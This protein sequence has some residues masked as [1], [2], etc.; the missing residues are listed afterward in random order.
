MPGP[1]L[2]ALGR[3]LRS[4]EEG[5]GPSIGDKLG[6]K[7]QDWLLLYDDYDC[8]KPEGLAQK[9]AEIA[10]EAGYR[11]VRAPECEDEYIVMQKGSNCLFIQKT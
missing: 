9:I 11:K 4:Q 1:V 7:T 2:R 3:I 5:C 6:C 10:E 8:S